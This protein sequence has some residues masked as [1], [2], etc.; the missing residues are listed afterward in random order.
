M[1]NDDKEEIIS[2]E[3][4]VEEEG[5][6]GKIKKL[7]DDL[8]ICHSEKAEYLAGWQRA[9]ADFINAR[10]DEEKFRT[11]FLKYSTT[12]LLKNVLPVLDSLQLDGN[13]PIY[14]QLI[15]I[16]KKEGVLI[17][18][19]LNKKFDPMYHEAIGQIETDKKDEDGVI[20]EELQKGYMLYERV[21]RASK[22]KVG[23]LKN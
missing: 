12:N 20:L 21:L 23:I 16:L 18:D 22:V 8:K 19:A 1:Q 5:M 10:K 14:N 15:D 17:I 2:E 7:R 9:K 13:N 4:F 11:E 3:E 6:Q